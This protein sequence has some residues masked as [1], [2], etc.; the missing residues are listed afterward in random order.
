MNTDVVELCKIGQVRDVVARGR[1]K[2]Y[3][4]KPSVVSWEGAS[5]CQYSACTASQLL[6]TGITHYTKRPLAHH[7][8]LSRTVRTRIRR[9]AEPDV[10]CINLPWV[11]TNSILYRHIAILPIPS[12]PSSHIKIPVLK[13]LYVFPL[14]YENQSQRFSSLL[15][16]IKRGD[17]EGPVKTGGALCATPLRSPLSFAKTSFFYF[18]L[19]V[20]LAT[21]R[22]CSW[23]IFFESFHY[24]CVLQ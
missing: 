3:G 13:T 18:R 6:T 9:A 7:R 4:T 11:Q 1:K 23:H 24:F 20:D 8:Y 15:R 12:L 17:R 14:L 10:L 5:H 2:Q 22:R 19:I 16:I 21:D